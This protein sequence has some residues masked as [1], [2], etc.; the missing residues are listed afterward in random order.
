VEFP[1]PHLY[2]A[3]ARERGLEEPTIARAIEVMRTVAGQGAT[4][5]FTLKHLSQLTG[6]SYHYLREIVSR[7][8]DPYVSISRPKRDGRTRAIS[9]PEP[10]LMDV[11]RWILAHILNSCSP[12]NSS[13]A[14]QRGRSIVQCASAHVGARWM[15]KLDI[16]NFFPSI[17][18]HRVFAIFV[19]LGYPRL[20]SL[21]LARLCTRTTE[22]VPQ[23]LR[24]TRYRGKAPYHFFARGHLPQGSPTSGA[25]ANL[26]MRDTDQ[27]MTTYADNEGL[28]FTRYSDDIVFSNTQEFSREMARAIIARVAETL[29]S[30]GLQLH[31][32]KTRV[33]T[34]GARKIVLGLLVDTDRPRLLPE[35]K[36]RVEVH[37]RGVDKFG[38][39]AHAEHRRFDSILSMIN[40]IDGC[41]AFASSV[42]ADYA[43]MMT[44]R[45]ARALRASGYPRSN[46]LPA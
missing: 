18:E 12:D 3:E 22:P 19:G 40:H 24:V 27:A 21:E 33:I 11:Q 2:R 20:L 30:A 37:V 8:I 17:R 23:M 34:P 39:S 4:P 26:V 1:P 35:F 45:W 10:V 15:V 43:A 9:S 6:A 7:R 46:R 42:D 14:Y 25:L 5:V 29:R 32:K 28:T 36:R 31:R 44:E 16:H 38:L 41:I 13:F